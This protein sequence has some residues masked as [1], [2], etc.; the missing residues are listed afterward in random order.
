VLHCIDGMNVPINSCDP[1]HNIL[2]CSANHSYCDWW[3]QWRH[4]KNWHDWL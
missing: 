2:C 3:Q 4:Y 1:V